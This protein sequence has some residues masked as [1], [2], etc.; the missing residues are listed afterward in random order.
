MLK[1]SGVFSR[2]ALVITQRPG[3]VGGGRCHGE[4]GRGRGGMCLRSGPHIPPSP[5]L[6][7]EGVPLALL[8]LKC[9]RNE[10]NPKIRLVPNPIPEGT[11]TSMPRTPPTKRCVSRRGWG[12][13]GGGRAPGTSMNPNSKARAAPGRKHWFF[14]EG[15]KERDQEKP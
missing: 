2:R 6:R 14:Q 5:P 9:L 8:G 1:G 13:G 4:G 12:V 3:C 15:R 10:Q 7:R 11:N